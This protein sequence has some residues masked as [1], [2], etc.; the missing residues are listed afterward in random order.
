MKRL[1]WSLEARFE[2][3]LIV[4]LIS[5]MTTLICLQILLRLFD[6]SMPQ[7]EEI[8]RYLFVWAMYL[9]ISYAIRDER[10]IRILFLVDHL[11]ENL[12]MLAFN[13]AD[14]IFLGYFVTIVYVGRGVIERSLELGQIAP[15]T[16]VPVAVLYSSVVVCSVLGVVRLIV[17][18]RERIR[19][20]DNNRCIEGVEA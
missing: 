20:V 7:A 9:C 14:L 13:C 12:R 3:T 15:A 4:V 2:P 17:R 6:A 11:P 18:L 16:E 19:T 10:H 1:F 5:A 8:A